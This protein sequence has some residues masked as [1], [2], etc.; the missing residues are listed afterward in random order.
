MNGT[1]NDTPNVMENEKNDNQI[2]SANIEIFKDLA[3]RAPL[4][5]IP[6]AAIGGGIAVFFVWLNLEV[7]KPLFT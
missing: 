4:Y 3:F 1:Q 7:I 6:V 5:A 2:L